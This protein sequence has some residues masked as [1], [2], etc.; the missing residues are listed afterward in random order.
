MNSYQ[1]VIDF[2][3]RVHTQLPRLDA[4]IANAG[5]E[6]QEFRTAE[7]LE[8]HLNVN[9]GSTFL[10]AIAVLPKLQETAM[11][12]DVQTSLAFCGSMYHVF[13]PDDEF[14]A[15]LPEDMDMFEALSDS[16][17]TDVIWRYAL[18]KLMDHLYFHELVEVLSDSAT[19]YSGIVVNLINP[20]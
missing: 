5:T 14:D 19:D 6:L 2:G 17:R 3:E 20:E 13:G 11:V 16:A 8:I 15:G 4:L 1:S 18:S 7:D 12:Y 9:V 10:G